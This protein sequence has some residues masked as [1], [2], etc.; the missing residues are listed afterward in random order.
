MKESAKIHSVPRQ[1]AQR[2]TDLTFLAV[3]WALEFIIPYTVHVHAIVHV[4]PVPTSYMPGVHVHFLVNVPAY[5]CFRTST[6]M[7]K[8]MLMFMFINIFMQLE[9]EN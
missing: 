5:L 8:N 4:L 2:R 1:M 3:M 6:T 7:T 9:H